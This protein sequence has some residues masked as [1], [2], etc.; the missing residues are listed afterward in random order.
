MVGSWKFLRGPALKGIV[1]MILA[2][3]ILLPVLIALLLSAFGVDTVIA[4]STDGED[5]DC[6]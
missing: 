5:R 2:K 1:L 6:M 4:P 3:T